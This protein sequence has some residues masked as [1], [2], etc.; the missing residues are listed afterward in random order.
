MKKRKRL[1]HAYSFCLDFIGVLKEKK[2]QKRSVREQKLKK[3][4]KI[5]KIEKSDSGRDEKKDWG[6]CF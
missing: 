6:V 1:K 2:K 3:E 4:T 5:T